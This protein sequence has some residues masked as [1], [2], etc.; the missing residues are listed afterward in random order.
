MRPMC[1]RTLGPQHQDGFGEPRHPVI[2]TIRENKEYI[3]VLLR[4]KNTTITGWRVLLKDG[5]RLL[6]LMLRIQH[7]LSCKV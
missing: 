6:L 3:S 1:L 7:D 2:V 5:L 4:S